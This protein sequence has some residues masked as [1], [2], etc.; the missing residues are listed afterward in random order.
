MA[1]KQELE[2]IIKLAG[3]IDPSLRKSLFDAQKKMEELGTTSNESGGV[4][5]RAFKLAASG[6]AA[7]G[8]AIGTALVIVGKQGLDLASDLTEVQNVVDV[9]FGDGASEINAWSQ[10]VLKSYGLSELAAKQYTGTLGALM[11]SSGISSDHLLTMSKN[12]TTLSGDF[13]SFYNLKTDEAFEKISA[14]ISGETEPLKALGINMSVANLEAYALSQGIKTAY[15]KMSQGDQVLLRYNYLLQQSADAQ[16]DFARTQD[17]YANQQRLFSQGFK[18]MSATIM[19][20]ALPA[21]TALFSKGNELIDTF[22]GS[23][24]KIKKLQDIVTNVVNNIVSFIPVAIN[25]VSQFI[26]YLY[27]GYQAI[28]SVFGYVKDNLT[29]ITPLV[30]GIV[31]AMTAWK[32]ITVGMA[33]YETVMKA[34]RAGTLLATVAQWGLNVAVLAN[35]MTWIVLGIAAAIGVLVAGIYL[36]WQ[37]WEQVTAFIVGLWQNTVL[38]FFQ[39]V[40]DWFSG[41]WLGITE[42]FKAAWS[43]ITSW[44]SGLWE[45]IIGIVKGYVNIYV[46]IFNKI[47]SAI[48]SVNIKIPD[49]VPGLGGKSFGVSIPEIPTFAK[50]GFTNQPSIFGEAGPEAAIPLK[51]TPRSLSL[52]NQ[53]ARMI[54]ADTGGGGNTFV[55]APV[56]KGGNAESIQS[57]LRGL[58]TDMF[59]QFEAWLEAQRRESF[60]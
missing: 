17:G 1:S 46:W 16:G 33:I 30:L 34:I 41:I 11:K 54:G 3:N 59:D 23:P 36:L 12:L 6:I 8:T 15:D 38:P 50:G 47:I 13:A 28:A 60:A 18:Q 56:I 35:P 2:A 25:L 31:S 7:A 53:T 51:R 42:G 49:W 45:G 21:F 55:F 4:I 9:T 10:T 52:L 32:A 57:E 37:N 19:S 58:A 39:G 22:A 26:G 48:N 5:Q 14:G 20:A 40:G 27:W 24:E 43:G 29:W 44:F